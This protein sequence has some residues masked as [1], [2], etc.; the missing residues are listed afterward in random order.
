MEK[1]PSVEKWKMV[2]N[3]HLFRRLDID[4]P[5]GCV[6]IYTL[7]REKNA[8]KNASK[9]KTQRRRQTSSGRNICQRASLKITW[10]G[11]NNNNNAQAKCHVPSTN[12]SLLSSISIR[13]LLEMRFF[14]FIRFLCFLV[15]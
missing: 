7:Y 15:V 11:N 1:Q 6:T 10:Q 2:Q 12:V 9:K 14:S 8:K 4:E 5:N 3:N 13:T